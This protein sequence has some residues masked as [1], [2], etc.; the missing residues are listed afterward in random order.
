VVVWD[1]LTALEV[2][3]LT[4]PTPLS[5]VSVGAGLPVTD[6]DSVEEFPDGMDAGE[7]TSEEIVGADGSCAVAGTT[8][9]NRCVVC[10]REVGDVVDMVTCVPAA[11][12]VAFCLIRANVSSRE[13]LYEACTVSSDGTV[14]TPRCAQSP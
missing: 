6:H 4:S 7:A 11:A 2:R 12:V 5:M 13:T 1:G 3:P 14:G 8:S 10:A 9:K